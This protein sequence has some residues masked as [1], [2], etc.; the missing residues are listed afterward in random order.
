M[1]LRAGI[2]VDLVIVAARVGLVAEKVHGRVVDAG[3]GIFR[4]EVL[5]AVGFVPAG[6][7]DVKGDLATDRVA[8][9]IFGARPGG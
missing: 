4:G 9:F 6:R 8:V 5:Q 3:E 7:E 2:L 1:P